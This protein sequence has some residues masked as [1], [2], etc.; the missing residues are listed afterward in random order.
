VAASDARPMPRKNVA[1]RVTFPILDADG[2]LVTGATGLDSEVSK[3]G[4]TFADCTNEATEIATSSGMYFLDLTADEMNADTVA[5]IVKTSSSGAKTTPLVLYPEE[6][7]DIRADMVQL[8]GDTTAADNAESFFDGTGYSGTNNTIPS[9]TNV[10]TVTG[11]VGGNVNGS[12][13]SVLGNVGGNVTGSIG[14]LAT[15]A[16]ADVQAE[17]EEALQTYH[18]DHFIAS[19]DPGSI[20]ADSSL[21]AKLVSKSATPSFASYV[22]TTDSLEAIRDRGD[23]AWITATG[24]STHSAADVWTSGTRVLTAATNISGPIADQVWEE[25]I[26]DH[27]GT[28]GSTAEQLAAAGAA[29]D[30]WSTAL[31]GVYGAGT[32]G[33]IVGDN[34]NA[35]VSSRAT[36]TSVD[37]IDGIVDAILLDTGTD[38]VVVNTFT[39]AGKAEIEAEATDA[40][41]TYDPPTNAEMEARTLLAAAYGTAANQVTIAGYIDTEVAAILAAVDTEVAAIKTKTDALP[42]SVWTHVLTEAYRAT[43]AEGTAAQLF[44]EILAN[45]INKSITGTTL[46]TT[47]LDKSTTAKTY[48][49][50]DDTTPTAIEEAT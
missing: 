35:T 41:N 46:T 36:Q 15:Q 1:Y 30:P 25:A 4:G 13:G 24:F 14:S 48:T 22:N 50:D 29:G 49:L 20:V 11:N 32:A 17:A 26:A 23:A 12:V 10:T 19:A 39:T 2:D 9:V 45:L 18:L 7:G 6:V 38:G 43:G 3:D 37:T 33:K 34:L 27:S 8:S 31:P 28:V 21:L 47:K 40:L 44:Y 16:K 42:G 5:I